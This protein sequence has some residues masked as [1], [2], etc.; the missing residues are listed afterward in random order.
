VFKQN[1][2]HG[3]HMF[4]LRLLQG[5]RQAAR[6][7]GGMRRTLFQPQAYRSPA[8]STATEWRHPPAMLTT[9]RP[10]MSPLTRL[11][12]STSLQRDSTLRRGGY[13]YDDAQALQLPVLSP[14]HTVLLR[15]Y[16]I[17]YPPLPHGLSICWQP[18]PFNAVVLAAQRSGL[19]S[20]RFA[21]EAEL[22][23]RAP[24]PGEDAA[25]AVHH[26]AVPPAARDRQ[27]FP[28]FQVTLC[29]GRKVPARTLM[30]K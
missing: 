18:K 15:M 13:I 30:P 24:A 29:V 8:V 3:D 6:C 7:V 19:Q 12:M 25:F 1:T 26:H 11:G 23:V 2:K 27:A 5:I 20:A 16:T 22:A 14:L 28:A 10:S 17:A 9:V 21:V 4:L